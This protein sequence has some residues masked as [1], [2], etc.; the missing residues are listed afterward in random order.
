[1]KVWGFKRLILIGLL[2]TILISSSVLYF[3]ESYFFESDYITSDK[4]LDFLANIVGLDVQ[5]YSIHIY[6]NDIPVVDPSV[7]PLID[8][9]VKYQFTTGKNKM[10]VF[11]IFRD[12]LVVWCKFYPSNLSPKFR[13]SF[14]G[15]DDFAYAKSFLERL[16]KRSPVSYLPE[17]QKTLNIVSNHK[18]DSET[19]LGAIT[20]T[21][22]YTHY[23]SESI[24]RKFE[25][26]YNCNSIRNS[27]KALN[28]VIKDGKFQS[29]YNNWDLFRIGGVATKV[30]QMQA[31]QIVKDK[32]MG[33]FSMMSSQI[34][35]DLA[36]VTLSMQDKGNYTLYPNY[37]ILMPFDKAYGPIAYVH[38][39]VWGDTGDI[40]YLEALGSH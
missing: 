34:R 19:S 16:Q 9:F 14:S 21:V 11:V 40:G 35:D 5:Q 31:I 24:T 7:K 13:L 10:D 29:F 2:S 4:A 38:A 30:S 36:K 28:L 37:D 26:S 22:T 15:E 32:A 27:H 3:F 12:E 20:Q 33:K 8:T 18:I 25:W 1:L 39:S 6:Q 23:S 17:M